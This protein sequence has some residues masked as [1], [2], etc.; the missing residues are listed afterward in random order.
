MKVTKR[1]LATFLSLAMILGSVYWVDLAG[2]EAE[3]ATTANTDMLEVKVQVATND[4][5]VIR[6]VTSVDSLEYSSV[7]FEVT[8]KGEATKT[9][10]TKTVYERIE[11]TTEGTEYKFSPKV[12]DT[13]S[14]YFVTAKLRATAGVDYVVRAFVTPLEGE[15][16]YGPTRC[17]AVEDGKSTTKLNVSYEATTA[18]TVGSTI[19][20]TYGAANTATT[21]EVIYVD[22]NDVTVRV[23]VNPTTLPS[24]TKFTFGSTGSTIYRNY[25]T[26]HVKVA[27]DTT[28]VNADRTWY[29]VDKTATEFVIAT[30]ADLYGLAAVTNANEKFISK[31]VYIVADI[32]V[33]P[34]T[35]GT[36]AKAWAATSAKPSDV[37]AW[38]PMS[39][40]G[41]YT[42]FGG[43]LDGQMHTISGLYYDCAGVTG[44]TG[45]LFGMC[46]AGSSVKNLYVKESFYNG[47]TDKNGGIAG[48][49]NG[50]MDTVYSNAI[51]KVANAGYTGGLVGIVSDNGTTIKNC[52]FDG[53]LQVSGWYGGYAGGILGA[54]Y[55]YGNAERSYY[56]DNCLFTGTITNQAYNVPNATGGIV[57]GNINT[58]P[59]KISVTNC[60]SA[61]TMTMEYA[62]TTGV[63]AIAGYLSSGVV[64]MINTYGTTNTYAMDVTAKG[65]T[66]NGIPSGSSLGVANA[67]LYGIA[68][69]QKTALDFDSKWVAINNDVPVLKAFDNEYK[70]SDVVDLTGTAQNQWNHSYFTIYGIDSAT[71]LEGFSALSQTYNFQGKSIYLLDDIEVNE[72]E[73]GTLAAWRTGTGTLPVTWEPIGFATAFA[74]TFDGQMHTVSG[75]YMK[76]AATCTTYQGGYGFFS[77]IGY[78]GIA[79][80]FYLMDS[81]F[82]INDPNGNANS[83]WTNANLGSAIGNNG[84][85]VS[86]IYSN[87]TVVTNRYQVGG[88]VG[89]CGGRGIKNC[90]YDGDIIATTPHGRTLG[91]VIGLAGN[92]ETFEN[93]LFTG[94][95]SYNNGY[96]ADVN[97]GGILGSTYNAWNHTLTFKNCISAGTLTKTEKIGGLGNI[98]GV[99]QTNNGVVF[100]NIYGTS[101]F[102]ETAYTTMS[103]TTVTGA[104]VVV[105]EAQLY[106]DLAKTNAAALDYANTWVTR[107]GDVPALK[108]FTKV[109]GQ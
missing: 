105:A 86:N 84:G 50:T 98:L 81:Y 65:A 62:D 64:D 55:A 37:Y 61:G 69:Y 67:D 9:Y 4:S 12:V 87:A 45:L 51:V 36:T 66:L 99:V 47:T 43:T 14:E 21:A 11:S 49:F 97:V 48:G 102:Y 35:A 70:Q 109:I 91:G 83:P 20:V 107:E 26:T 95:I 90:W 8:P 94:S 2:S 89:Y 52:W 31:T 108:I 59:K 68:G 1:I 75:V 56:I 82:E 57:G 7:G 74:G 54:V 104:P 10:T 60:L 29:D 33:N 32:E 63:G 85:Q 96:Y 18:P 93:L 27:G 41:Y 42:Y 6:F 72:I 22:G 73:E 23:N 106:G 71:A 77:Q 58:V 39:T 76:K 46:Q 24:A 34:T 78:Y 16:V 25:Y 28:Q 44:E 3:A 40:G 79:R 88:I 19:N 15:T 80:N 100:E 5:N 103:D 13:S 17:V 101:D 92:L 53:T 38:T 30:S